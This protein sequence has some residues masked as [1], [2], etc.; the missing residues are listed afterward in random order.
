M[1]FTP[2][3]KSF[4]SALLFSM[5]FSTRHEHLYATI[6]ANIITSGEF[7]ERLSELNG[8][9]VVLCTLSMLSNDILRKLGAFRR[10]PLHTVVVDEASQIEIGDYIPLFSNFTTVRKVIFIGDNMQCMSCLFCI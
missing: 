9:P 1:I 5:F 4:V 6:K 2:F 10:V 3:G 8:C 7:F